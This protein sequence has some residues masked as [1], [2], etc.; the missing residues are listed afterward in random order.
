MSFFPRPGPGPGPSFTNHRIEVRSPSTGPFMNRSPDPHLLAAQGYLELEMYDDALE[1]LALARKEPAN[2][3]EATLLTL[4]IQM[5]R[6]AWPEALENA[7]LLCT[8]DPHEPQ[9][10]IH[11]AYVL[12]ELNRVEEAMKVLLAGPESLNELGT[13]HYNLGCYHALLGNRIDALDFLDMGF[14]LDPS[15]REFAET[16]PDL[17]S[18]RD[19]LPPPLDEDVDEDEPFADPGESG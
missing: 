9:F 13:F 4:E 8:L 5:R 17:E 14:E 10:T 11:H 7:R 2:Q 12:R 16:D 3:L 19:E 6:K 18:I 15:L 1:E